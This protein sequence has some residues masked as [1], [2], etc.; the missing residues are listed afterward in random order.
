MRIE[1][2]KLALIVLFLM[3]TAALYW[4]LPA[5]G[6]GQGQVQGQVQQKP[7]R[8]TPID[9]EKFTHKTHVGQVEVPGT[10]HARELKCDSCHERREIKNSIISTTDRNKQ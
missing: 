5:Q 8:T 10:N 4:A 7:A 2:I 6:Q 9:Y 1:G 3:S